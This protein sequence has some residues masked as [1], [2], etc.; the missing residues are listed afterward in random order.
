MPP[1]P[2]FER[3]SYR[4]SFVPGG[5]EVVMGQKSVVSGQKLF[6]PFFMLRSIRVIREI[7]EIRRSLLRLEEKQSTN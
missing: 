5:R 4:P 7:R 1:S 6:L 2:I 3:I